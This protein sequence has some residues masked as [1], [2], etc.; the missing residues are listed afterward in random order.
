MFAPESGVWRERS[1]ERFSLS[2][3][4]SLPSLPPSHSHPRIVCPAVHRQERV[5]RQE[6]MLTRET[7][8]TTDAGNRMSKRQCDLTT[9]GR[10]GGTTQD[11]QRRWQRNTGNANGHRQRGPATRLWAHLQL[12][13]VRLQGLNESFTR[14]GERQWHRDRQRIGTAW[15]SVDV[16]GDGA[17][18]DDG[19]SETAA[20]GAAARMAQRA[21][22]RLCG[23]WMRV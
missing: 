19:G 1:C 11:W 13:H 20:D 10:R 17:E 22:R 3:L 9:G 16:V 15:A 6:R 12:S 18:R 21:E 4:F 8:L 5:L 2:L 14:T 7:G 23:V